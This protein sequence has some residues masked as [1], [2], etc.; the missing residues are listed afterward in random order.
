MEERREYD[1]K[2]TTEPGMI[3][4]AELARLAGVP[5]VAAGAFVRRQETP[6]SGYCQGKGTCQNVP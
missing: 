5:Q 1:M 2:K 6:R 3:T 4:L